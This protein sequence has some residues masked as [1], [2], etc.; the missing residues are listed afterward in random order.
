MLSASTPVKKLGVFISYSRKDVQF[1]LKLVSALEAEGLAPKID[2]RDLPKLEDWRREL[3]GFI[4][5]ADAVIFI[6]SRNSIASPICTW[7]V[8][9]VARLNKRLAPIVLESVPD[10]RIPDAIAKINY[11]F[12]DDPAQFERQLS[13]LAHALQVDLPWLKEHTRVS[14]LARRWDERSRPRSLSLHGQ[15]LQDAENWI[16]ARPRGAPEPT[17]LH[18]EFIAQ[19]RRNAT[20]RTRFALASAIGVAAIG[21][22]LATT[23]L[24][25][26]N[27]AERQRGEAELQRNQAE[28]QRKEA[29]RQRNQV[30]VNQSK[31][32]SQASLSATSIGNT[33]LG[34]LLALAALPEKVAS[35]NRPIIPEAVNA[36]EKA[37]KNRHEKF[38][39]VG[40]HG[41][42]L[43]ASMSFDGTKAV[44]AAED[45]RVILW[46]LSK[47]TAILSETLSMPI[48]NIES[49]NNGQE[50][51]LFP[52]SDAA[53]VA[54]V[55]FNSSKIFSNE[56]IAKSY[57]EQEAVVD[58]LDLDDEM[59]SYSYSLNGKFLVTALA[60]NR[61]ILWDAFNR[62]RIAEF[63]EQKNWVDKIV[64]SPTNDVFVTISGDSIARLWSFEAKSSVAV[65]SQDGE[66][67]QV[68]FSPDGRKLIAIA[69]SGADTQGGANLEAGGS[70][71]VIWDAKRGISNA[72]LKGMAPVKSIA[73]SPDSRLV[74]SGSDDGTAS[75]WETESGKSVAKLIGHEAAITSV[76]FSA[77]GMLVITASADCTARVWSVETLPIPIID[78]NDDRSLQSLIDRG[79]AELPRPFSLEELSL[80]YLDP[81]DVSKLTS[82]P[83]TVCPN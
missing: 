70:S 2:L 34:T 82:R 32:L 23:A 17:Q 9:Q 42:V 43:S 15:E 11:L 30:Y 74:V 14:E 16:A 59:R 20:R 61:I 71:V 6:I 78:V 26:R 29:E 49:E 1:A 60:N 37:M 83:P 47:Q 66:F 80:Y 28:Q 25:Q 13:A 56:A 54:A 35:P 5:Q 8:E 75:V 68:L 46:D 22:A 73:F 48:T 58:S 69:R 4:R 31:S 79:R 39:L 19:S 77:D 41:K 51:R 65:L 67:I 76:R 62:K 3:L 12:F 63:D 50:L 40:N 45:K 38:I 64:F 10:D 52:E 27:L 53:P 18:R 44:T 36:L 72:K 7:E 33:T 81:Q 24:W 55:D 21:F 57:Q